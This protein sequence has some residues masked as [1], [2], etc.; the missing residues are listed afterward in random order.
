[1][2]SAFGTGW[3][4]WR[5]RDPGPPASFRS[6]WILSRLSTVTVSIQ[7]CPTQLR[8]PSFAI[9]SLCEVTSQMV[10]SAS[11][12]SATS[13]AAAMSLLATAASMV[14]SG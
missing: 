5:A 14:P 3:L 6:V 9:S 2:S 4:T 13:V 10:P 7:R 12:I 1:M 11:M 8:W